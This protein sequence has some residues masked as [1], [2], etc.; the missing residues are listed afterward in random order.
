MNLAELADADLSQHGSYRALVFEGREYTNQALRQASQRMSRVL[1]ELGVGPDHKVVLWLPNCTEVL[2]GFPAI[3]R[4]GA[5]AI[6]VLPA[7]GMREL[8][9]ILDN[10]RP[11]VLVTTAAQLATAREAA[12]VAGV[13]LRLLC[14][15]GGDVAEERL[16]DRI[17]AAHPLLEITPRR[18]DELAVILYTSGTTGQPKGVMQTHA[19]LHSAVRQVNASRRDRQPGDVVLLVLPL[20][21]TFGLSVLINAWLVP[22]TYV[23][24]R[25]FEPAE[26]LALIERYRV[27]TMAGVPTM[28]VR[29]LHAPELAQHDLS[30]M[31]T[32][33]VG[34]APMPLQ[35][36]AEVERRMGGR[37]YSG[38]GLTESCPTLTCDR[39][40][41]PSREGSCGL[42]VEGVEVRIVDDAD[43]VLG[44]GEVGEII[45]R[46][47][48]IVPGYYRNPEATAE[49]FRGGFLH[50]GDIGKL[51]AEG[52]LYILDRKKDLI[53]R[54]GFNVY[55]RDVEHVLHELDAVQECA[56]VGVPDEELGEQVWAF[57]VC[58][59]GRE[60]TEAEVM[61][62]SRAALARYKTPSRVIFLDALPKNDVGKIQKRALR[63]RAD[64]FK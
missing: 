25:R 35:Q 48:N 30:S 51:D 56:V 55:P 14:V 38:Y 22:A 64:E 5:I 34:G 1:A 6:P 46:G 21:H 45:A 40:D 23:V 52:Y 18:D 53:I 8:T 9:H 63:A 44:V 15:D 27:T 49:T 59:A 39:R 19:N 20:A 43:H 3:W 2:I 33:M 31:R 17:E 36:M 42:V 60:L 4:L 26:V 41:R 11:S 58:K 62:H 29:L 13:A 10:A 16:W 61:A 37:L 7:L 12:R 24:V 47:P 28:Y 57:V 54:G 50:T 32:W